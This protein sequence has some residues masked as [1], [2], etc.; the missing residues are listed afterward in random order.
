[1]RVIE[2]SNKTY[3]IRHWLRWY[4]VQKAGAQW[5][6][7]DTKPKPKA[8]NLEKT[9]AAMQNRAGQGISPPKS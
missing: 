5:V 9:A 8:F 2:I 3:L 1:M 4:R 7:L 6:R